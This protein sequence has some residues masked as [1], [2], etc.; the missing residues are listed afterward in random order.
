MGRRSAYAA[1]LSAAHYTTPA[2]SRAVSDARIVHSIV[3][4]TPQGRER[5]GCA[6]ESA[7][8][9]ALVH[10]EGL[11]PPRLAAPEPK[12]GWRVSRC[13]EMSRIAEF[14]PRFATFGVVSVRRRTIRGRLESCARTCGTWSRRRNQWANVTHAPGAPAL[15]S[16]KRVRDFDRAGDR[17]LDAVSRARIGLAPGAQQWPGRVRRRSRCERSTR[18][19]RSDRYTARTRS[20]PRKARQSHRR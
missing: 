12:S 17:A 9:S 16:A 4:C 10:Q 19:P 18:S 14:A 1:K 3:A 11:E 20:A 15:G 7:S 8:N 13:R 5:S 2:R 6:A